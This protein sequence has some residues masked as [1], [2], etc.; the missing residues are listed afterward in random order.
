MEPY[1]LSGGK[2]FVNK[3][4]YFFHEPKIKDVVVLKKPRDKKYILKVIDK[5]HEGR[6]FVVGFNRDNSTD[7]REFGWVGRSDILGKVIQKVN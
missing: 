1:F 5:I 7:S 4:A 3:M 6:Y 2:V